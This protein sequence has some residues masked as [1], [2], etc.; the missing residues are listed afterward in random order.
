MTHQ[1]PL[2]IQVRCEADLY[3]FSIWLARYLGL[4]TVS[5]SQSRLQHGWFWFPYKSGKFYTNF[6]YNL[7]N[8]VLVQNKEYAEGLVKDGIP[9]SETGLPFHIFYE[10]SGVKGRYSEMR[11]GKLFVPVRSYLDASFT[12]SIINSVASFA[13]TTSNFSVLLSYDDR[14]LEGSIRR[15][16]SRVEIGASCTEAYSFYRIAQIFES[17]SDVITN[18]IGSHVLYADMCGANVVIPDLRPYEYRGRDLSYIRKCQMGNVYWSEFYSL[19]YLTRRFP[20]LFQHGESNGTM[21]K[22]IWELEGMEAKAPNEV[23]K[24]LGWRI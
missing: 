19:P 7:K 2:E 12:D 1:E 11:D 5:I 22:K 23:A 10:F 16:A 15:Y 9:S 8:G 13:A 18:T 14:A 20:R 4:N 24:L 3:G 17:Y 6:F 21:K